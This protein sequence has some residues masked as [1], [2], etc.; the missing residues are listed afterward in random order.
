VEADYVRRVLRRM[1]KPDSLLLSLDVAREIAQRE[2]FKAVVAG[3]LQQVG[4][5]LLVSAQVVNAQSGEVLAT[6]RET[7]RDSTAILDAVDRV[8]KQLRAKI[9]ESLRSI[10]ANPALA[11]VTTGSLEALRK[12]SQALQAQAAGD[13]LGAITLLEESIAQDSGFAMAWRKLGTMLGNAGIKMARAEEALTRAYRMRDRLTLRERK[14]TEYSYFADVRG[15]NDSAEASLK[16]LL[17]EYPNDSWAWNNLGVAYEASGDKEDAEPA[18]LRAATLEPENNLAWGNLLT[19]RIGAAR[20][21]SAAATLKL[22]QAR[23]PAGALADYRSTYLPLGRRDFVVAESLL[24]VFSARYRGKPEEAYFLNNLVGV[25]AIRGELAQSRQTAQRLTEL[26]L[27]QGDSS[28]ALSVQLMQTIPTALY[29]DDRRGAK[30]AIDG[31][32]REHPLERMAPTDRPLLIALFAAANA[33]DRERAARLQEELEHNRGNLPGRIWDHGKHL[34]RGTVLA[35]R[36]ETRSQAIAEFRKARTVCSYCAD[37]DLA[38]VY[39]RAGQPDSALAYYQHWADAGENLWEPGVY[40]HAAPIAYFRLGELYEQKN[41]SVHAI[42]FYN[43]F[44]ILWRDA[45]P[46]LQPKVRD[47]QQRIQ[48]LMKER[49]AKP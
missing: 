15:M 29:R 38:G 34:A 49:P 30:A 22:M 31:L 2:G 47:A 10:R 42:E 12:Y 40:T 5:S 33:G 27:S 23:F 26:L 1:R 8:S 25:E 19:L 6:A 9:G 37:A 11:E 17:A 48:Q 21:D 4:P 3:E 20:F 36:E 18:Y 41:D 35:L 39:D 45:D 28:G 43:K 16:S 7:A 13:N 44:R 46:E 32:L 24:T 14:L